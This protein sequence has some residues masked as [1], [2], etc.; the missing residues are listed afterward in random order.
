MINEG[1]LLHCELGTTA[2]LLEWR[3][4]LVEAGWSGSA[5]AGGGE[6]LGALAAIE[7]H[8]P[9]QRSL[10]AAQI[11]LPESNARSG[12]DTFVHETRD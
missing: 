1:S 3:D 4:N 6:T 9:T 7:A 11:A 12:A 8:D 2:V 5:I 10:E